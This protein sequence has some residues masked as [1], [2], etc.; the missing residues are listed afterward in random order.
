[1]RS[2]QTDG[3]TQP[4]SGRTSPERLAPID[5][6]TLVGLDSVCLSFTHPPSCV[7]SLGASYGD[8]SLLW[9][10]RLLPGSLPPDRSPWFTYT[11]FT[12]VPSPTTP[13]PPAVALTRYPSARRASANH[14]GAGLRPS[15]AGSSRHQAESSSLSYGPTVHLLLLPTPPRG[16]AVTFDYRPENACL[17]RTHTS[18]TMHAPRRT[19]V[20]MYIGSAAL[21]CRGATVLPKPLAVV[22]RR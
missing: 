12:I 5:R 10:L 1:M 20:P 11:A 13:C 16:D 4:N 19:S 17:K 9:T 15:L 21:T 18:L 3:S 14:R 8:S 6:G 22:V 2:V 7:P